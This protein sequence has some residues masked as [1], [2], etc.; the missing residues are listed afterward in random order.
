MDDAFAV[1]ENVSLQSV[2]SGLSRCGVQVWIKRLNR[3][4]VLNTTRCFDVLK[5]R[6]VCIFE[7]CTFTVS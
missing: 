1:F 4:I 3:L 2:W 5:V 6:G 7:T